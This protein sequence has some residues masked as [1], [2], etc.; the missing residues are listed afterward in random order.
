MKRD[1]DS[2][3]MKRDGN[4][5]KLNKTHF[6]FHFQFHFLSLSETHILC[7]KLQTLFLSLKIF[8]KSLRDATAK[9]FFLNDLSSAGKFS[10]FFF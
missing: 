5:Q 7:S 1:G 10:I 8:S 4:S 3:P 9:V 6:F 2:S